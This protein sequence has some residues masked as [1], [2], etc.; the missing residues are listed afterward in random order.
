MCVESVDLIFLLKIKHV[1]YVQN[2][3]PMTEQL[4]TS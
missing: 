3:I 4:S 1:Y 2:A